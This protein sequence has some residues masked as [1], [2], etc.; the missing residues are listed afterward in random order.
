MAM[1]AT[2]EPESQYLAVTEGAGLIDRSQ[3]GKIDLSGPDAIEYLQGQVTNDIKALPVGTGCYAA[4]LNP[5]GRILSD[6]RVLVRDPQRLW[7]DTEQSSLEVALSELRTYKIG[8]KVE[9]ADRSAERALLSLLGANSGEV[10]AAA[11]AIDP[12]ADEHDSVDGAI[13]GQPVV[14]A[15][16]ALGQDIFIDAG[17]K[18]AA[19]DA[20]LTAGAEPVDERA[21]ELVRIE[22]GLPRYGIDMS[23]GNLPGEAGIVERAVSFTKGCYVGQEPVAR[24]FHKGHPNRLLRGLALSEAVEPGAGLMLGDRE[25][26]RVGSTGNSP[27]HGPIAL[28]IVRKEAVPGGELTVSG[29]SAHATV[30]ELPFGDE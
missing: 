25:V 4:L 16:S 7:L 23:E 30:I 22:S 14:V 13:A 24:M 18:Q 21:A 12:P 20:L 6:A 26:G 8:R 1:R 17:H 29:S 28:A 19:I 5:K 9:V 2:A 15:R 27:T 3:R 10:V 11:A